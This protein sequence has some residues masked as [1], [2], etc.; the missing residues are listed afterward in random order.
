[1]FLIHSCYYS[2]LCVVLS[3]SLETSKL[4]I[5]MHQISVHKTLHFYYSLGP[6]AQGVLESPHQD[7]WYYNL[8]NDGAQ[9]GLRV[10]MV[11]SMWPPLSAQL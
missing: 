4:Y 9:G 10:Q 1:M 11:G 6:L 3:L 7:C 5:L 8:D 2:A